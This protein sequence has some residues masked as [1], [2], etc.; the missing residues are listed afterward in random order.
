MYIFSIC[1]IIIYVYIYIICYLAEFLIVT[2]VMSV[3]TTNKNNIQRG[4]CMARRRPVISAPLR[5]SPMLEEAGP[6]LR[7]DS[8]ELERIITRLPQ[9]RDGIQRKRMIPL[10][11]AGAAALGGLRT[12]SRSPAATRA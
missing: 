7:Q 10:R 11:S 5:A 4:W 9:T 8:N 1:L 3:E 6:R 2:E 12:R